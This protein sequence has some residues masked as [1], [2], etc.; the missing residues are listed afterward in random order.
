MPQ[1]HIQPIECSALHLR[2]CSGTVTTY[3]TAGPY[4]E[5]YRVCEGCFN[6]ANELYGPLIVPVSRMEDIEACRGCRR[7]Q[8][9][10]TCRN[11]NCRNC[12]NTHCN[13]RIRLPTGINP[14]EPR[15]DILKFKDCRLFKSTRCAGVE[16]EYNTLTYPDP[17]S[18]FLTRTG[19]GHHSD[20]SCG[21][22]L[23][24]SPTCG[25]DLR[26]NLEELGKLLLESECRVDA[27]CSLHTHVD[28]RDVSWHDMYKLI[29]L[30][31][32]VEPY[33]YLLGGS[34]RASNTYCK[35]CGSKYLAALKTHD[36]KSAII[37]LALR[38]EPDSAGRDL[39]RTKPSKKGG[40]RYQ[41]FNIMP[42]IASRFGG[43]G[44]NSGSRKPDCTI[45]FRIHGPV[46]PGI[47]GGKE[48]AN[49]AELVVSLVDFSVNETFKN[50]QELTQSTNSQNVLI[51][52]A[53]HLKEYIVSPFAGKTPTLRTSGSGTSNGFIR[54]DRATGDV[55][56]A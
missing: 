35:P 5:W 56:F 52:V 4:P 17:V 23:V 37:S 32:K 6:R 46:Q 2:R 16:W 29:L 24:T 40:S 19:A 1:Y 30:Y 13:C 14:R 27:R 11:H 54:W 7:R 31:S 26:K 36:Y 8:V 44:G 22:E 53:P 28:A 41:G 15:K 21:Y 33:L 50:I 49:W 25:D 45:E 34:E 9:M 38:G 42:W 43:K 47:E 12:C 51:K 55:L 48:A 18:E 20:G 39:I 3:I 10:T